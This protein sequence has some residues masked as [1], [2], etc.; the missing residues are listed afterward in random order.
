MPKTQKGKAHVP[1]Q[2]EMKRLFKL[3]SGT[4]HPKR[5][6]L[7]ILFS[8]GL[9]LRVMEIAGL[10]LYQVFNADGSINEVVS[11]TKTKGNKQRTIY[12]TDKRI[13]DALKDYFNYRKNKFD[14]NNLGFSLCGSLF[15]T[16]RGSNFT[17][18]TLQKRF[19]YIY[20]MA[21][22]RGA[23]SHSGRRAFA[24]K[25]IEQG[26]DIKA[27]ATLMGHESITM[28]AQYVQDNPD[29]LKKIVLGALS[30]I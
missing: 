12:I 9:G 16:E 1:T 17:N 11:L 14:P 28:T 8:Y 4:R 22:I 26:V 15:V 25:L 20:K 3:V 5:D 2:E 24:T 21:G 29:R 6:K 18:L 23:S 19:E 13:Q 30:F 10:K 27:I 7:L